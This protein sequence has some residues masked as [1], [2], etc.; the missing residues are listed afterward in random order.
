MVAC[1]AELQPTQ[2]LPPPLHTPQPPSPHPHPCRH[3]ADVVAC[4]AEL[5]PRAVAANMSRLMPYLAC[6][7][8]GGGR[9]RPTADTSR[10]MPNL[11]CA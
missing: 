8:A 7:C 1:L 3:M 9:G 4:L 10:I 2:T 6:T 5:Q 11:A